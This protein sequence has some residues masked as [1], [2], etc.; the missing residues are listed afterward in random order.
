MVVQG[1]VNPDEFYVYKPT[2]L[3]GK[4]AI[5]RRSL[6][7]KQMRMVYSDKPGERVRIEDTPAELRA[8]FSITDED[9]HELARQALA[10][11]KHYEP[12]DGYRMGQGRRQRQALHRPGASGNG[13]VARPR[14]RRSSASSCRSAA[15]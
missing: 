2:L 3:Q 11:E 5:L 9:V 7:A 6:G 13:E 12:P 4:P 14:P 8:K 1:A 10:I 15:R